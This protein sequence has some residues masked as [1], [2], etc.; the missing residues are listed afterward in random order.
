[1]HINTDP[2]LDRNRWNDDLPGLSK[3]ED[4]EFVQEV[5]A[6]KIVVETFLNNIDVVIELGGEDA[7]ILFLTG[8]TEERMN[9]TCTAC[10]KTF[11]FGI[12]F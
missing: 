2:F 1:L 4:I 9:G 11:R 8:G 3:D 6:T 7:R 5:I 12:L 10:T